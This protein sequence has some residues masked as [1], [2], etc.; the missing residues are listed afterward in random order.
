MLYEVITSMQEALDHLQCP[1][2]W[3]AF[4]SDWLYTP[5]QT[6]EVV[7]IL[8]KLGKPVT[9]HLVN[10]SYGHDSFLVEPEKFTP[11]IVEFLENQA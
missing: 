3:F 11:L 1:S 6:E 9:Y 8:R 7:E 10:S 2:L 4:S 5:S